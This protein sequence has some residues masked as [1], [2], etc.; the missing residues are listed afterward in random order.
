MPDEARGMAKRQGATPAAPDGPVSEVGARRPASR[1][2]SE[3]CEH[4]QIGVDASED[5]AAASIS[6][7][8]EER[9]HLSGGD[10]PQ[11][12]GAIG[13]GAIGAIGAGALGGI[14][15]RRRG[16]DRRRLRHVRT[17]Q[18]CGPRLAGMRTTNDA[19]LRE[20]GRDKHC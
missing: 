11:P 2:A 3:Y 16:R 12:L 1:V 15:G 8:E 19:R 20:A 14:G 6:R 10:E 9:R 7:L 4:L 5:Q 18:V 17:L 13:V